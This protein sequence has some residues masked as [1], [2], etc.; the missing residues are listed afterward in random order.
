MTRIPVVVLS[1]TWSAFRS[2]W[3]ARARLVFPEALQFLVP[4]S[5][6][7]PASTSTS[8]PAPSLPIPSLVPRFGVV[9][10]AQLASVSVDPEEGRLEVAL[11]A[12]AALAALVAWVEV[13]LELRLQQDPVD[14]P[15]HP[16]LPLL[17]L[18]LMLQR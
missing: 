16:R 4:T 2:K 7:I 3:V 12:L 1:S 6:A 15:R 10:P 5:T 17:L 9:H 13:A 14:Q 18:L 11:V 8:T